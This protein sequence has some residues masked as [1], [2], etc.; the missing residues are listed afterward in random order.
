MSQ[1]AASCT[2]LYWSV[3]DEQSQFYALVTK[4]EYVT[5]YVTVLDIWALS[6]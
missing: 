6:G 3:Q 5:K 1:K 4:T 2:A